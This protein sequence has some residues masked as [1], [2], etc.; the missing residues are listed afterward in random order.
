VTPRQI[1]AQIHP[2]MIL[3]CT[4]GLLTLLSIPGSAEPPK[5][6]AQVQQA[7]EKLRA[8]IKTLNAQISAA[9]STK[10]KLEESL[11]DTEMAIGQA[12]QALHRLKHALQAKQARTQALREQQRSEGRDL[13]SQ[14]DRLGRQLRVAYAMGQHDGLKVLLRQKDPATLAR[15]MAYHRYVTSVRAGHIKQTMTRLARLRTLARQLA[16]ESAALEALR[17]DQLQTQ[18]HLEAQRSSRQ[19]ILS[20]L[21]TIQWLQQL[22][23]IFLLLLE[24]VQ[25]FKYREFTLLISVHSA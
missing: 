15:V 4:L 6:E 18:R 2:T 9:Q 23:A 19:A 12:S 24:L 25:I 20:Q 21:T 7:L 17:S 16:K 5:Q 1:T 10:T 22:M 11:K 13:R 8:R 3:L 14:R